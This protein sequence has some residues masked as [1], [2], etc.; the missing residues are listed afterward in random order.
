MKA[1]FFSFFFPSGAGVCFFIG[2]ISLCQLGA[3]EAK[4]NLI[5]DQAESG[6]SNLLSTT[7]PEYIYNPEGKRDPFKPFIMEMNRPE[8][9]V[10]KALHPLQQYDISQL[11]LVGIIYKADN[12]RALLE[13]AAGNGYIIAPG[14]YVGNKGG[15]VIKI[16]KKEVVITEKTTNILGET[17]TK[18]VKLSLQKE[19]N[20]KQ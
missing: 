13:D 12:P 6:K 7:N 10:G 4:E 15:R 1:S 16:S 9:I 8:D 2:I 14:S 19:E 18:K 17:R 11:K 3:L 5:I 20:E